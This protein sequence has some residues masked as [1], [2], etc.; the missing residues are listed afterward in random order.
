MWKIA[1]IDDDRQVLKGMKQAIPWDEIGAEWVGES[2]NGAKGLELIRQ[3]KPDIVITDVYMP[4]M[5]GLKMIEKLREEHY[6]GKILIHSGYSDFEF[7]RK[8]LRLNVEDYLSKPVSRQTLREALQRVIHAAE[9]ENKLQ[10]EQKELRD[11][12][13]LYEPFV[14]K[15]WLKSAVTGTMDDWNKE[16]PLFNNDQVQNYLVLGIEI[17]RTTRISDVSAPDRSLF[18]FAIQNIIQEIVNEEKISFD[19]VEL[20]GYH[21]A[22]ILHVDKDSKYAELID[23][24]MAIAEKII[25]CVQKYLSISLRIGIGGLKQH[26]SQ[27]SDSLEEA[28]HFLSQEASLIPASS[29]YEY[30]DPTNKRPHK[31]DILAKPMRFFHQ[32]IEDI[33]NTQGKTAETIIH[34]YIST[35]KEN[36]DDTPPP[37]NVLGAQFWTIASYALNDEQIRLWEIFTEGQIE[38]ELLNIHTADQFEGWLN[39][40]IK[41]ICI[42]QNW[43]ENLKHKQ[44][45]DFMK[46]YIHENYT[47]EITLGELAEKVFISRNYLSLIFKNATGETIN[48][49][50]IRVRM[51]K[52]RGLILKGTLKIYEIAESVGYKNIPYF[53]TTFKKHFGVTPVELIR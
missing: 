16:H 15:E 42:N 18:R 53:S 11:K 48:N 33:K 13:I 20:H 52:A 25:D 1:I 37:F 44:A 22:L 41:G 21:T 19:F 17:M 36:M 12:V 47:R 6:D 3:T 28:F 32:L 30:C 4:V 46:Q 8:A 35:L 2:T 27:L 45:V 29:L 38:S 39:D 14:H 26:W 50:I 24:I 49:Y 40:K 7:A 34:T 43:H 5:D 10:L 31:K 51:E 9:L 23:G